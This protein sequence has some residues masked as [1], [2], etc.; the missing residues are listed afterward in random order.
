MWSWNHLRSLKYR[1]A[2]EPIGVWIVSP[3]FNHFRDGS[4][5]WAALDVDD[6]VQRI[7]DAALNG[8]IRNLDAALQDTTGKAR[9]S[10]ARRVRVNGR[11]R[12]GV[13]RVEKLKQV[14]RFTSADLAKQDAI[15]TVT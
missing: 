9:K 7:G 8:A 6:N 11:N 3:D 4:A 15:R 14:E 13:A 10:F 1:T 2:V 5:A 12:A